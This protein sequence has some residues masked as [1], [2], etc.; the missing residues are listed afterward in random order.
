MPSS[1]LCWGTEIPAARRPKALL[2]GCVLQ[3]AEALPSDRFRPSAAKI[4]TAPSATFRSRRP[5]LIDTTP[6]DGIAQERAVTRAAWTAPLC[7][8]RSRQRGGSFGR[9][10]TMQV[11]AGVCCFAGGVGE[12]MAL[13]VVQGAGGE[14]CC[15]ARSTSVLGRCG[16][17]LREVVLVADPG[18]KLRIGPAVVC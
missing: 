15:P 17:E 6:D 12:P 3:P 11:R 16:R 7:L 13:V 5:D 18:P 10:S 1:G 4:R 9:N 14:W 2:S 8:K